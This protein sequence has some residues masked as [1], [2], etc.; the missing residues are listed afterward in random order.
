MTRVLRPTGPWGGAGG[1]RGLGGGPLT[2]MPGPSRHQPPCATVVACLPP[3]GWQPPSL[4][5]PVSS[6]TAPRPGGSG[7]LTACVAAALGPGVVASEKGARRPHGSP[8]W[9]MPPTAPRPSL[10]WTAV[11]TLRPCGFGVWLLGSARHFR[12]AGGFQGGAGGSRVQR[13][14]SEGRRPACLS[15][16]AACPW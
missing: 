7:G 14:P 2:P 9:H 5:D 12:G 4:L 13:V 3:P 8:A 6:E 15:L 16:T 1:F 10:C 11:R